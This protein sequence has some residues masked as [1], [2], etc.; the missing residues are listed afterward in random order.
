MRQSVLPLSEWAVLELRST[1]VVHLVPHLERVP[2]VVGFH[3][4]SGGHH[5]GLHQ[6]VR[7]VERVRRVGLSSRIPALQE[8]PE[9]INGS[10]QGPGVGRRVRSKKP[11]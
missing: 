4:R 1:D 3:G 2:A 6:S 10:T 7:W 9:S 5:H 8:H 11:P